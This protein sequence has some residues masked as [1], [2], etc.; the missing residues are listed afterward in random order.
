MGG[1][2]DGVA[3]SAAERT[4][5]APHWAARDGGWAGA[6]RAAG[7]RGRTGLCAGGGGKARS[8]PLQPRCQRRTAKFITL[9]A[10]ELGAFACRWDQAAAAVTAALFLPRLPAQAAAASAAAPGGGQPASS[11]ALRWA[12]RD[13]ALALFPLLP[14]KQRSL[15]A[16]SPAPGRCR[17]GNQEAACP[18]CQAFDS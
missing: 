7:E 5:A 8:A 6:G 11:A 3:P 1:W 14:G 9:L 13:P 16:P 17:A 10:K 2:K 15:L 4:R 12:P 18:I